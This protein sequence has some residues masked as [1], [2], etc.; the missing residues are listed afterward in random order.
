[1]FQPTSITYIP[2]LLYYYCSF[3]Q[4]LYLIFSTVLKVQ[5]VKVRA[6]YSR[7]TYYH[8]IKT[9]YIQKIISIQLK[10]LS[11]P[12]SSENIN[13]N[14][15]NTTSNVR[16]AYNRQQRNI[17]RLFVSFLFLLIF[18]YLL[19][20]FEIYLHLKDLKSVSIEWSELTVVIRNSR[21]HDSYLF[22]YK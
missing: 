7:T 5:L 22:N 16:D 17:F 8:S 10:T 6:I 11:L 13:S 2:S 4:I 20:L 14:T 9:L 12:C 19:L 3:R 1:M 15:I 18:L 21:S